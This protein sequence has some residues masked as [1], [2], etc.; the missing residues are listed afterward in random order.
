MKPKYS[1]LIW[2]LF[3]SMIFSCS[4]TFKTK[5]TEEEAPP[6]FRARF[7]TTKGIFDIE[8][9]REWSPQGVDRLYQ[10]IKR[11]FY[12]D[13]AIYR[14]VP[15]FVAQFGISNDSTLNEAWQSIR[16]ADE[17]VVKT[18]T[19]GT[20]AFARGGPRSRTTQIFVNLK[21][22]SPRLDNLDYSGVKGFPVIAEITSGMD[23]VLSFYDEYG[24]VHG[25][26]QDSIRKFGNEWLREN[27]PEID[28]ILKAYILKK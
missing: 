4:P 23:V 11:G 10:L 2:I 26:K 25:R 12:T 24:D 7:E 6:Y 13:I 9:K 21:S 15:D 19:E 16:I 5:W 20:I 8:A 28:Y 22:N 18:N 3:T 14:V 27:Y 17:P 1:V